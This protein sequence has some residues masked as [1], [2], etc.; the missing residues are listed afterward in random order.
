[1]Q[2]QALNSPAEPV[3]PPVAT[4]LTTGRRGPVAKRRFQKGCFVTEAGGYYSIYYSDA[5][6]PDGHRNESVSFSEVSTKYQNVQ[7]VASTTESC[8]TLTVGGEV[9]LQR[10]GVRLLPTRWDYGVC[11][12]LPIYPPLQFVRGN[13]RS[14]CMFSLGLVPQPAR[15][16]RSET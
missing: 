9:S 10:I 12:A 13:R 1:M 5:Q 14:S 2:P 11:R 4:P 8:R 6:S 7:H 3:Y 15:N 16:G